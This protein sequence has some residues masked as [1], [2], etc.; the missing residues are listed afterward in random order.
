MRIGITERGDASLDFSWI[1]KLDTVDGCI[2][3]T[4]QLT[5]TFCQKL[6]AIQNLQ[7]PYLNNQIILHATCTGWGATP[8]EPNVWSYQTQIDQICNLIQMGFPKERIVLRIDPIF[9]TK[10]GLHR[11]ADVLA[12]AA[13]RQLFPMRIRI[14]ILDLYPHVIRRFQA[15]GMNPV[16]DI[17]EE[18]LRHTLTYYA[19]CYGIQFETCAE[20]KLTGN[21]FSQTG[22]ISNKDIQL[23][24][25]PET[26]VPENPQHRT[27]CHCLSVKTELLTKKT[28][29]PHQCLYCYW[30]D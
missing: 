9:P 23:L 16:P 6:I 25:L 11:L 17:S 10:T 24:G 12:Y 22:C 2:L 21:A 18:Q 15:M 13:S 26:S 30:H 8:I 20:P 1:D 4:K 5:D 19:D 29:C 14:S 7:Q 27:G 28:R 3:I